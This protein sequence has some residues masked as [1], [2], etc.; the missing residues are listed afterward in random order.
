MAVRPVLVYPDPLLKETCPDSAEIDDHVREVAQD[1]EE[2]MRAHNRCVGLAA[3]Q[4]GE[5]LR[6]IAINVEGHP[7]AEAS[8]GPFVLINPRVTDRAGFEVGREGCLS[9]PEITANVGRPVRIAF[10]GRLLDGTRFQSVASGFEARAVLHEIDHLDGILILDRVA[11]PK[12][13]FARR[14]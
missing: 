4:I 3:P 5:K 11:S 6:I 9:L 2:T 8:H 12:E 7:R 10:G 13:I 14:S 1:L